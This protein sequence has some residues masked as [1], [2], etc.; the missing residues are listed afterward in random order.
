MGPQARTIWDSLEFRTPAILRATEHLS[1]AELRWQPPNGGNSIAWLLWH[2]PEV[3]DNWIRDKLLKLPK[4]YPFG[5]SVKARSGKEW[6]RKAALLSYFHDVRA[7]TK[8]RLAQT[9]EGEF[10]RLIAD[11]HFGSITVRQM[12]GGV[13]TSC[14]WH[15]GQIVFIANRLLP[16]APPSLTSS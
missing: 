6:P 5:T 14:A 13:V 11:E 2:I 16:K 3:E 7:S 15:G 10:D 4:R 8:D 1:E 9:D 12:W